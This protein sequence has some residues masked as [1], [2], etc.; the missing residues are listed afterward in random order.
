MTKVTKVPLSTRSKLVRPILPYLRSS[1]SPQ[2][3]SQSIDCVKFCE[4]L[5]RETHRLGGVG[6]AEGRSWA[7]HL[8]PSSRLLA[9]EAPSLC[10]MEILA[11]P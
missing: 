5:S 8:H 10:F 9:S 11:L 1:T 3:P 6:L 4:V 7:S 2:R